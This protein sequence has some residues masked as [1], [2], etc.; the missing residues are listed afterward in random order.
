MAASAPVPSWS[1][2][3]SVKPVSSYQRSFAHSRR[4]CASVVQT[5]CGSALATLRY[6]AS[7]CVS[8]A[9]SRREAGLS[10]TDSPLERSAPRAS[11]DTAHRPAETTHYATDDGMPPVHAGPLV[12]AKGAKDAKNWDAPGSR[13][14][15]L[16]PEVHRS[17]LLQFFAPF[18]VNLACDTLAGADPKSCR[19][20]GQW[21][22]QRPESDRIREK[23]GGQQVDVD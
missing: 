7:L 12:T 19:G 3:S 14:A 15:S 9:G 4:P 1:D 10:A 17:W 23:G 13:S 5:I 16:S 6:S 20:R 11:D 2:S 18:A 22:V 21:R 8:G